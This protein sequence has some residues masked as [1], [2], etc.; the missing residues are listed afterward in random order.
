MAIAMADPVARR[1]AASIGR[2]ASAAVDRRPARRGDRHGAADRIARDGG[3]VGLFWRQHVAVRSI[4]NRLALAQTR[5]IERAA[6]DWA[7]VILQVDLPS[8]T[9][10]A[11]RGRR[12]W[13]TRGWTRR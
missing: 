6:V 10:S 11:S 12:R 3:G 7:R 1:R 8:R 9:S 2:A 13:P 5:W 4:E